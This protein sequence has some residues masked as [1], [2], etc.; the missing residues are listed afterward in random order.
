M[1]RT[2]K[3]IAYLKA[4]YD[5]AKEIHYTCHGGDFYGKHIFADLISDPI[6]GQIDKVKEICLL[7]HLPEGERPLDEAEYSA[8]SK[9]L[10]PEIN[11]NNDAQNFKNIQSLIIDALNHIEKMNGYKGEENVIGAIAEHLQ[12]M[13]GLLNLQNI[14]SKGC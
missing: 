12:Q 2:H 3:L 7:G 6:Y 10:M 8:M 1:E 13:N 9:A 11:K 5:Y 4:I 14:R